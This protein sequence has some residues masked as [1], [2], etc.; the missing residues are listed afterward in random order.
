MRGAL[1]RRDTARFAAIL[2]LRALRSITGASRILSARRTAAGRQASKQLGVAKWLKPAIRTET[3]A[4][5]HLLPQHERQH[6]DGQSQPSSRRQTKRD[7]AVAH[8]AR[9]ILESAQF[10]RI[11]GGVAAGASLQSR[12]TYAAR[13]YESA[14]SSDAVI[15][16]IR[17]G[18]RRGR[19][20]STARSAGALR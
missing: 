4:E 17:R 19:S 18:M 3:A 14:R 11:L 5:E 6:N 20:G 13:Q 15:L 2:I 1:G 8:V 10:G 9:R 7:V 16:Q 12:S